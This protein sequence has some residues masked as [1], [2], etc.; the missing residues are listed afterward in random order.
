MDPSE[1]DL[2]RRRLHR[3]PPVRWLHPAQLARAGAQVAMARTVGAFAA[4][5]ENEAALPAEI[6]D[7]SRGEADFWLDYAADVGD[8]FDATYAVARSIA[9]DTVPVQHDRPGAP[10]APP[11]GELLV[12][13]GDEAYPVASETN[14]A[15]RTA[16][17]YG[18]ALPERG[19]T[20]PALLAVPGNHDWY[21]GLTSF[22]RTFCQGWLS[23]VPF[24][25]CAP[26]GLRWVPEERRTT[27]YL[28]GWR[29]LQSRSYFAA[30]L[31]HDW[32]LWGIDIQFDRYVDAPQLG[33]F[34]EAATQ[35]RPH[36]SIILCTAK[37]S[38]AGVGEI[39]VPTLQ[40][41]VTRTLGERA[42]AIR[43]VCSGDRHHYARYVPTGPSGPAALVT[44]GGGGAYLSPTHQLPEAVAF[45]DWTGAGAEEPA[46]FRRAA[47]FPE[48]AESRRLAT[49][50]WRLPLRNPMLTA[51]LGCLYALLVWLLA[52]SQPGDGLL[53]RLQAYSLGDTR[54]APQSLPLLVACLLVLAVT[55]VIARPGPS[56]RVAALAGLGH[57]FVHLLVCLAIASAVPAIGGGALPISL[58]VTVGAGFTGG[59]VGAL[60]LATYLYLGQRWTDLHANELFA[61]LR[62]ED[63]KSYL[64]IRI[65]PDGAT[66][67]PLGLRTVPRRWRAGDT[68]P[69]LEPETAVVAEA[70][71]EPF[72]VRPLS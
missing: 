67:Y 41:F 50:F 59:V 70:I 31:P 55:V 24:G 30:K 58:L 37:P 7:L 3:L 12:L 43:L 66:V 56:R 72:T 25:G 71:D 53:T 15:T 54:L 38:W 11:H 65:G 69:L 23:D 52:A 5:R 32:W 35:L 45:G 39:E 49:G 6:Y 44:C 51:M 63:Y 46:E 29:T 26:G 1:R 9:A 62:I 22:L 60:V 64:R 33:Y 16:G 42:D 19:A 18:A 4:R 17:P 20:S 36:D 10:P 57:G 48:Q 21:D 14:Y 2:L 8:G 40:D 61:G 27:A 68:G 13:G 47:T 34:V 28:G